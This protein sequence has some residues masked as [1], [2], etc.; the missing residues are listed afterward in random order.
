MKNLFWEKIL[1][2]LASTAKYEWELSEML[3]NI[4][5]LKEVEESVELANY[6]RLKKLIN[7]KEFK[8]KKEVL[9]NRRYIDTEE[10]RIKSRFDTLEKDPD[11]QLYFF[12]LYSEE[13]SKFL[14]FRSSEEFEDLADADKVRN[15]AELK[16]FAEYEQSIH[17]KTYTRFHNSFVV[18]EFKELK[19]KVNDP[20]FIESNTFWENEERWLTTKEYQKEKRFNELASNS[21]IVFYLTQ[22]SKKINDYIN[23]ETSFIESF[24]WNTL[25]KTN[26]NFG[27]AYKTP[28]EIGRESF[29]DEKQANV[30]G[31]NTSV[32]NGILI[33]STKEETNTVK[34][35]NPKTKEWEEKEFQFTSDIIQTASSFRQKEGIF[36]A[37]LKCEGNLCHDF[38]LTNE[39]MTKRLN[40]FH[41]NGEHLI[42]GKENS[43]AEDQ[44]SGLIING[45][46]PTQFYIFTLIWTPNE[47]IWHINNQEVFR[48][49]KNIPEEEMYLAFR[50][51]IPEEQKGGTGTLEVDW[52]RVFKKI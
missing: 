15:S 33:L 25:S 44:D 6:Y 38:F 39:D 3:Q 17:Y 21:D 24:D 48:S 41:F 26:W 43:D 9:Q 49:K 45:L 19:T 46:T 28:V 29:S 50:S 51:Y 11:L 22:N 32:D 37:K 20:D 18:S 2:I 4:V 40:V 12:V 13:L 8:D 1:G 42:F 23:Y 30:C 36:Q 31:R 27:Y 52:V 16:K 7:S 35:W 5:R 14:E 34:S 10:W 47:L